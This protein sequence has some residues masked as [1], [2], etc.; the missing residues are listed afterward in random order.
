PATFQRSKILANMGNVSFIH[1]WRG[2]NVNC[3]DST[4]YTPLHHAA[5][6]GHS[7]VVEVLLRNEA[8]TNIADNKGC[9]PLHLAAWKGDQRIVKLLIHQG[10]SHPKLNEQNNDNETPL[11]C[12]AQY[13]HTQVVQLLLEELT[14]PTMRNN[15]F[16]TPLDLAALY[17]R[18]EVVKLLLSAHPNL[19]SSNTKKHTP[20]HL[21]SRNGHLAV[22]EVLLAAGVD[23]NYQTEKGSA[24][25][26]AALFGKTEVV[27]K[28]LNAAFLFMS[29]R[30]DVREMLLMVS[31]CQ[32]FCRCCNAYDCVSTGEMEQQVSELIS[33]LASTPV[34][35]NPYE[36]LFEAS[37]CVSLDSL[38]SGK[39]SDSEAGKVCVR[40]TVCYLFLY[41]FV[42]VYAC[43]CL[44]ICLFVCVYVSQ[45]TFFL[46]FFLPPFSSQKTKPDL[47]QALDSSGVGGF[48]LSGLDTAPQS[49]CNSLTLSSVL[50]TESS[51][52]GQDISAAVPEQFTGLLHGSSPVVDCREEAFRLPSSGVKSGE[53]SSTSTSAS[54]APLPHPKLAVTVE[55]ILQDT[56]PK[57]IYATVHKEPRDSS[58]KHNSPARDSPLTRRMP[59]PGDLKLAR[60]L[61]KSDSDLLVSPP[62]EEETGLGGRSE[63]VSNCSTTKRRLE[64]SPSFTSEW[65]EIEKIMTLIGAGIDFSKDQECPATGGSRRLLEQ[66]VGDWLEHIG[67]PQY[68]S[69]LLLNGFDDLRFMGN[70]VME[71]Q[72]LR[73]IGIMDPAHRRKILSAARSLPKVK[74]LGCDGSTSLAAWLDVLGLQEYLQNFLSS[75]YRTLECV[76]NLWELEI[77]NVLKITLL[78]HRKRIIASLAER[79]YEE[80]PVKP[81]RLSQI[82]VSTAR[83]SFLKERFEERQREPRLT[84]RPPSLAAPYTPVQNW[85][86]QPEKL[87][88]ESCSYEAN[89]LGSMLIKELRGTE[90]TQDACAKMRRST[91][92]MRKIPT[93][94]LSITYKGVKFI[95]AANKNI[96]AEHEIRNISCAAQDPEDLCTFA[97]ITKDL[98]SSHHYCHVFSTVD[99]NLTYE[100]ILTLGQ[101][102]EVAYQLALQAQ[103][104]R[105]QQSAAGATEIIETKSSRPVP[106]PRG[107]M[108]KSGS[109]ATWILDS[110]DPKRT[111]S[112]KYETTIF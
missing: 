44:C 86:H 53:A 23:L 17:G 49:A 76:K 65:D 92:Q 7:E 52:H 26:E 40:D 12:A 30:P 36:A 94:V 64:K 91:E 85:H 77:V 24:L 88:F 43:V 103:R 111:V 66:P 32:M 46:H 69:K 31:V 95:D 82:R 89:Y 84:L 4:G 67:L 108:R 1:I 83:V 10:P 56:D 68:E 2:P 107:S 71:E 105:Q 75:G 41:L 96:I 20:L 45:L 70:D 18:L 54:S 93:I 63:S 29:S 39:S 62:G 37:S 100:I 14:D 48:M 90:S 50:L 27:Q 72:D 11:H 99:V 57:A 78:G 13:G 101:A 38:A 28:L 59:P 6:N 35:E 21:A 3:V 25:H 81:P 22:V 109:S 5:L 112:T 51:S 47:F 104:T 60:S 61:S 16:E 110:K 9:Y 79:P 74:A 87:I 8:L 97:Y 33:G 98:Q 58:S 34:E 19:L 106:K 15:K 42:C 55:T 80:P 102:F 73:E